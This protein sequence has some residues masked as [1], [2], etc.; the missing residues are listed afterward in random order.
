MADTCLTVGPL[1]HSMRNELLSQRTDHPACGHFVCS[2]SLQFADALAA[3]R[4]PSPVTQRFSARN[5]VTSAS[6]FV[7]FTASALSRSSRALRFSSSRAA[8]AS[9]VNRLSTTG[10]VFFNSTSA[11]SIALMISPTLSRDTVQL[12]RLPMATCAAVTSAR[13]PPNNTQ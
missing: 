8:A 3:S 7:R 4:N 5:R 11:D 1:S 6:R 2:S 10:M 9:A 13:L 12:N